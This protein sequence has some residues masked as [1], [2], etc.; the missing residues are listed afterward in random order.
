MKESFRFRSNSLPTM[1]A[2]GKFHYGKGNTV[3]VPIRVGSRE[4]RIS[5]SRKP[6]LAAVQKIGKEG[7]ELPCGDAENTSV[8]SECGCRLST[9]LRDRFAPAAKA[10]NPPFCMFSTTQYFY[11][12]FE[13]VV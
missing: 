1:S 2:F 3:V 8:S 6:T 13:M 4:I 7:S 5:I 9:L 11:C 12:S 10:R